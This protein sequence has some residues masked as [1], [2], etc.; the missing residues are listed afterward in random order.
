MSCL[1]ATEKEKRQ[2]SEQ[3]TTASSSAGTMLRWLPREHGAFS[4]L[5]DGRGMAVELGEGS[6][7][8][9]SDA[10]CFGGWCAWRSSAAATNGGATANSGEVRCGRGSFEPRSGWSRMGRRAW[11]HA[12]PLE[13]GKLVGEKINPRWSVKHGLALERERT[14]GVCRR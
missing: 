13:W 12:A 5:G 3:R 2:C 9:S 7:S 11:W 1:V 10:G 14:H 8:S 4:L 6:A